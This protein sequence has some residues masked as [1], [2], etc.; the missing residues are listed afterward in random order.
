MNCVVTCACG[1][2]F[3]TISTQ[4]KMTVDI[5]SACH[6]FYTGRQKFVDTEGRVKKLLKK[7]EIAEKAPKK[8]KKVNSRVPAGTQDIPKSKTL[9]EMLEEAQKA[10]TQE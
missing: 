4:E 7:M 1:N 2:T 10:Q 9:K 5:C 8:A 6:P 3:T